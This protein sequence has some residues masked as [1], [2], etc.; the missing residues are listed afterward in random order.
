[1]YRAVDGMQLQVCLRLR[2]GERV[3]ATAAATPTLPI[4]PLQEVFQEYTYFIELFLKMYYF[5]SRFSL[6]RPEI[7]MRKS[8]TNFS[9]RQ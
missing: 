8:T 3:Q 4:P 2:Q 5:N 1:M 6:K 7:F 9:F